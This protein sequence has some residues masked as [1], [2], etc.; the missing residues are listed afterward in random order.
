MLDRNPAALPPLSGTGPLPLWGD[1]IVLRQQARLRGEPAFSLL[2]LITELI[3]PGHPLS[4]HSVLRRLASQY[5][6]DL[7]LEADSL[8]DIAAADD[9]RPGSVHTALA[10]AGW[11][12]AQDAGWPAPGCQ[13]PPR[14]VNTQRWPS[15]TSKS[16]RSGA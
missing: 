4:P 11:R 9:R 12:Q 1:D 15:S 7:P 2:D 14:P 8:V 5:I 6:V 13:S 3:P 16:R 10:R